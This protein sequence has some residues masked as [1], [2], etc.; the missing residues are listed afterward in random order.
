LFGITPKG[1]LMNHILKLYE[2]IKE[3]AKLDLHI[4]NI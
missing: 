1:T 4:I 2:N 3:L